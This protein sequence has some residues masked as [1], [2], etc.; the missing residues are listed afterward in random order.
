MGKNY[1]KKNKFILHHVLNEK[2]LVFLR[3][4]IELY[5]LGILKHFKRPSQIAAICT[6]GL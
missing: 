3:S 6:I 1:N 2:F 5:R 4:F